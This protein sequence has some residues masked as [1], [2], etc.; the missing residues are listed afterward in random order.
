MRFDS[1]LYENKVAIRGMVIEYLINTPVYIIRI[2]EL[3]KYE[4]RIYGQNR[5]DR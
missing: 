1:V 2:E 4:K 5:L 3:K